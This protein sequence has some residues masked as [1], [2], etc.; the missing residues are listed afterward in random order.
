MMRK[1]LIAAVSAILAPVLM[2]AQAQINTKM[3]KIEDFTEKVT[4]VVLTG[5]M[6]FDQVFKDEVSNRWRISPFEFCTL[7]EFEN[8]KGDENHYFLMVVKGQFRKEVRPGLTMLSVVKG[9]KGADKGIGSMLDVVTVPIMS[10]E[11]PTGREFVF[12]PA[13]LDILQDHILKSME[14]D[15]MAYSG[16][17]SHNTEIIL[18]E[19]RNIIFAKEDLSEGLTPEIMQEYKDHGI[20][21][22]DTDTADAIMAENTPNAVVSFTVYPSDKARGS[23]CYKMLIDAR[24]HELYYFRRHRITKNSGPGFLEEDMDRITA[25]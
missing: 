17:S 16:L 10:T 1:I 22:T 19:N 8:M 24:T 9:G 7:D 15:V 3:A 13:L 4:E 14:S 25:R 5:N 20:I 6:F 2:N 18:A 11:D 12:L 23:Y 21:V